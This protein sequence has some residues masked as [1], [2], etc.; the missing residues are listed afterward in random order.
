M[1]KTIK[2]LTLTAA[3]ALLSLTLIGQSFA[4][5][6]T[7]TDLDNVATKDK[8]I[9]LQ[10]AGIVSG[11]TTDLFAPLE[12]LSTAQA[13]QL[14]VNALGLNLDLIRFVKE[15]K[16]TDY[17]ANA[18]NDAWYANA[19]I[20]AAANGVELPK[21][22]DP[23]KKITREEFT[24][25]LVRAIEISK[26]LPLINPVLE[27]I[28][29]TDQLNVEYSGSI[30]RALKYG[31][32]KLNAE[33]KFNP[34]N[35]ITRADA[36]EEIFNAL[37]YLKAHPTPI[38]SADPITATQSVELI[39][40]ALG[41]LGTDIQIKIDPD[42]KVTRE[43]FTYMLIHTL[44]TSEKLPLIKISPVEI[45]DNDK[46]DILHVGAIQTALALDIVELNADG[47][48]NPQDGITLTEATDIVKNATK[49]VES[50]KQK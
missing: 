31:I 35:E 8:I 38:V 15:P 42:A 1:K 22:L 23:N 11:I 3:T 39:K 37:A 19:F 21:D 49:A 29:D 26:G 12:K 34:K 30:Q 14:Y 43:S 41:E 10:Q 20:V 5:S 50:F 2:T 6:A 36:A 40:G 4:A 9:S 16:A 33:G 47:A 17:F 7:F 48:F 13:V 18:S 46:M 45:K 28:K 32:I 27:D 25:Q 44:Q 24:H